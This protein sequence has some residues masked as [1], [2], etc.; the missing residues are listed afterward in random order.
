MAVAIQPTTR[1]RLVAHYSSRLSFSVQSSLVQSVLVLR[2]RIIQAVPASVQRTISRNLAQLTPNSRQPSRQANQ[3][4]KCILYYQAHGNNA[5]LA[6]R[7][8]GISRTTFYR[9]LKRYEPKDL[10]SLEDHSSKPKHLSRPTWTQQLANEV[11]S[12]REQ[13][14]SWGKDKLVVL[15]RR[16][17]RTVSTSVSTSMVGRILKRLRETHQLV[18]PPRFAVSAGKRRLKREYAMRKPKEYQAKDPGDIVE[19]DTLDVRPLPGVVRKQFTARD[20]ISRYDVLD[21]R[22]NATAKLASEFVEDVISRMPFTVKAIQVDNGSEFMA[23]FEAACRTHEIK[24]FVLPPRSP[25]LNGH[26]ERA[27]RTHT[28]EHWELSNGDT[29]VES[30]RGELR[31]WETVYNTIRPHQALKYLTPTEFIDKWKNEKPKQSDK[32]GV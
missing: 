2:M 8:F 10:R 23:E 16:E 3:R 7:R 14:P 24:L 32:Q 20:I 15:L 22:S 19:I 26:V 30:M 13:Y 12:L 28:E 31:K 4:L 25:K 5:S 17:E 29:D 6:S 18:E 11:R 27:Q 9:W 21:I 1:R